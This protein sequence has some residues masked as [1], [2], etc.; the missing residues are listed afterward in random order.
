MIERFVFEKAIDKSMFKWGFSVPVEL[1][2]TLSK[3]LSLGE[4]EHGEKR[5]MRFF[6]EGREYEVRLR[7]DGFDRGKY[8]THAEIWQFNYGA[9]S[10]IAC[11]LREIFLGAD[12]LSLIK[13]PPV[14]A[15]LIVR[16]TWLK[17]TFHLEPSING[18]VFEEKRWENVFALKEVPRIERYIGRTDELDG[19]HP[20]SEVFIEQ[21]LL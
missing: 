7:S 17:D 19:D 16:S 10:P 11:R 14:N 18:Q 13:N 9:R 15:K 6:L 1:H 3:H 20:W 2:K 12:Q 21:L 5:S 8:P 4:L